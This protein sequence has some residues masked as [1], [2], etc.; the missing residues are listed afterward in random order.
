MFELTAAQVKLKVK[1][2]RYHGANCYFFQWVS[3]LIGLL[4]YLYWWS[5][6]T[7][8]KWESKGLYS[9]KPVPFFGNLWKLYSGKKTWKDFYTDLYLEYEGHKYA[10]IY[11]LRE[12]I[13][14]IRDI[15]VAKKVLVSDFEHFAQSGFIDEAL[16]DIEANNF[17]M[18]STKGEEWK[19][20]KAQLSPAFSRP[21]LKPIIGHVNV[22]AKNL[23]N[24]LDGCGR[25]EDEEVN[26]DQLIDGFTMDC[27]T[28]TLFSMEI[29][30]VKNP[31]NSFTKNAQNLFSMKRFLFCNLFP[32]LARIF[33]IGMM[34]THATKYLY[35]VAK[36]N[37]EQRN[38][39][40]DQVHNDILGLMLK[41][42]RDDKKVNLDDNEFGIKG[43]K[44]NYMTDEMI[45]R[46]TLQFFIDGYETVGSNNTL[47]LCYLAIYPH[48]QEEA[49]E[50]VSN[51]AS[52]CENPDEPSYE[53]IGELHY[54]EQIMKEAQRIGSIP[55]TS[56]LCTKDWPLPGTDVIIPKG[57]RVSVPILG[58]HMHEDYFEDP[59]E[60]KPERFSQAN[61]GK[62]KSGTYLPF[63]LGPRACMGMN[64]ATL[65]AKMIMYHIIRNFVIEPC[66]KT[67]IPL[68]FDPDKFNRVKGGCFL[69]LKRRTD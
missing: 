47:M 59:D 42:S 13:L 24:H 54:L 49:Y 34:N 4:L 41:A 58:L 38:K 61:R 22:V 15:D 45:A 32:A 21:G 40:K 28:R 57:M 18:A 52:K 12:P 29:G 17:G 6:K 50:E 68:V 44:K 20:L 5:T 11:E 23:I 1:S 69:K 26:V 37:I 64:I 8:G 33:N 46:T 43:A 55:Y 3:A 16:M 63:G 66:E 9:I 10:I 2:V 35:K 62:I 19:S 30:A 65:E 27:I 14:Y 31:E 60:F 51:V 25:N 39:N 53:A 7:F 36:D 48:I 67:P 56:R